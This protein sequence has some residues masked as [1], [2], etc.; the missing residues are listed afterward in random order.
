MFYMDILKRFRNDELVPICAGNCPTSSA[1]RSSMMMCLSPLRFGQIDG[2][3]Q[4]LRRFGPCCPHNTTV[5]AAA[6]STSSLVAM[7]LGSVSGM[8]GPP[9]DN[10]SVTRMSVALLE[11]APKTLFQCCL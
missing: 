6:R 2:R 8:C 11:T 4:N 10:T 3:T 5:A 7:V 9:H 1:V